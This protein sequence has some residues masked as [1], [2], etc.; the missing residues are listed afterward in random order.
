MTKQFNRGPQKN[1]PTPIASAYSELSFGPQFGRSFEEQTT[2]PVDGS[3]SIQRQLSPFTISI[4]PPLVLG[5]IPD[6]NFE[7][8]L[9]KYALPLALDAANLFNLFLNKYA[10]PQAP[11]EIPDPSVIPNSDL[12]DHFTLRM[13]L[14]GQSIDPPE[15]DTEYRANLRTVAEQLEIAK[16]AFEAID[17]VPHTIAI[18]SGYRSPK[19]NADVGGVKLSQ[20]MLGKAADIT[21]TGFTPA[22]VAAVMNELM[23]SGAIAQGGLGYYDDKKNHFVHYDVRGDRQRFTGGTDEGSE[24]DTIGA[25]L[26]MLPAGPPPSEL[27]RLQDEAG[28]T[29][30]L[31]RRVVPA[32]PPPDV[33]LLDAA[34]QI[35]T[36][37]DAK[38]KVVRD[39]LQSE[40]ADTAGYASNRVQAEQFIAQGKLQTNENGAFTEPGFV[41]RMVAVDIASQL[42]AMLKVPPLT[43]LINPT[44]FSTKYAK[45]QQFSQRTRNGFL[46]QDWGEEQPV[47]SISG[48]I[49]AF[50]AGGTGVQF[51]SKR[52]SAAYQNLMALFGFYRHA[53]YIYDTVYNSNAY[54]MVGALAIEYDQWV[55]VGQMNSFSWGYEE[56]NQHGNI[57]FE[58][59]FQV[60]QMFDN[61]MP[62]ESIQ[63]LRSPTAS[64]SSA[65][66]VSGKYPS[67]DAVDGSNTLSE[68]AEALPSLG[69]F[70][71]GSATSG[72]ASSL[73]TGEGFQLYEKT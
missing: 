65:E 55:Y 3:N 20:H 36:W 13:F 56:A 61:H 52:N 41:D 31:Q 38:N 44:S 33:P 10:P 12:T 50:I 69:R 4:L 7:Q 35:D 47:L 54:H 6:R 21:V 51:A 29:G 37:Q 57:G 73:P 8:N 49:G 22:Q 2:V 46:R 70:I 63:P 24:A 42:D 66:N 18:G 16:A 43:L 27:Y 32:G 59:E 15:N 11:P 45:I 40:G 48:I 9:R 67:T 26:G 68:G 72:A 53:G 1:S 64:F 71:T 58:I 5:N 39:Q 62:T 30:P 23:D 34:S 25:A 14:E 17:G 28:F 19:K 60:C